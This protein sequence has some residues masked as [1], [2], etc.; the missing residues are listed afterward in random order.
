MFET[1]ESCRCS[2]VPVKL[3]YGRNALLKPWDTSGGHTSPNLRLR[4]ALRKRS[5]IRLYRW[6]IANLNDT[7]I[8]RDTACR[9]LVKLKFA[10][11]KVWHKHGFLWHTKSSSGS[12]S[13]VVL[14]CTCTFKGADQILNSNSSQLVVHILKQSLAQKHSAAPCPLQYSWRKNKVRKCILAPVD[15]GRRAHDHQKISAA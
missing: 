6:Y 13:A 5:I 4:L 10:R 15:E 2:K 1:T 9:V 7:N 14:H 12:A 3:C 8:D 11:S